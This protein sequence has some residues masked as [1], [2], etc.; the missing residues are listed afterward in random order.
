MSPEPTVTSTWLRASVDR[1]RA[2]VEP[3]TPDD[4]DRI[5]YADECPHTARRHRQR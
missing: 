5:S 3:L 1:L 2:V 4:L